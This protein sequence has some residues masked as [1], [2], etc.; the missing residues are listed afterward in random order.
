MDLLNVTS[1]HPSW[2]IDG[3]SLVPLFENFETMN[4]RIKP[5]GWKFGS[6][7]A[8]VNDT[9]KVV[10]HSHDCKNETCQPALYDLVTDPSET[11]D[12]KDKYPD[13]F[14]ALMTAKSEWLASVNN[15]Q[16]TESK[17]AINKTAR[18]ILY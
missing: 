3:T 16:Y 1:D 9:W 10:E 5:M 17:C 8:Y 11:I 7:S 4:H 15:S 12:L 2:V 18:M 6:G 13:M 14:N